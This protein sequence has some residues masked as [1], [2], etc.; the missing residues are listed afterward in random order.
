MDADDDFLATPGIV[1]GGGDDKQ[2]FNSLLTFYRF[3]A[4]GIYCFILFGV[5]DVVVRV[6]RCETGFLASVYTSR[7]LLCTRV[8]TADTE[9]EIEWVDEDSIFCDQDLPDWVE[10][11]TDVTGS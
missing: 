5:V 3:A 8:L 6:V 2:Q 11:V 4:P 10:D 7:H 9:F 1:I